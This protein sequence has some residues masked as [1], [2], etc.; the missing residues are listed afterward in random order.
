MSN[1]DDFEI[2]AG[3]MDKLTGKKMDSV[4]DMLCLGQTWNER[5]DLLTPNQRLSPIIL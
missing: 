5:I 3:L 2:A 1:S 4:F